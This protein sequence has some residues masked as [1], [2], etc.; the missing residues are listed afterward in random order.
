LR[1]CH[2]PQCERNQQSR[3]VPPSL[4]LY[5]S[6][7]FPEERLSSKPNLHSLLKYVHAE[8]LG[9]KSSVSATALGV[10]HWPFERANADNVCSLSLL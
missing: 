4:I 5:S 10:N 1:A 2:Q 3:A 9:K 8:R 7:P 6:V